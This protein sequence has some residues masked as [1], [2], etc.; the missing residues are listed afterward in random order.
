MQLQSSP[1]SRH[2][3]ASLTRLHETLRQ[4]LGA[5]YPHAEAEST[6]EDYRALAQHNLGQHG[7]ALATLLVEFAQG[8]WRDAQPEAAL[9]AAE[10][11]THLYR[12]LAALDPDT[13]R[14]KLGRSLIHQGQMLLKSGRRQAAMIA[15]REAVDIYWRAGP[16]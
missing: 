7:P 2:S 11:V 3:D 4:Q 10:E 9:E 8:R 16:R 15:T 14:P 6:L 13:Y 5:L 12:D 1:L